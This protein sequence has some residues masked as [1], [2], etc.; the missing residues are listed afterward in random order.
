MNVKSTVAWR[1][2]CRLSRSQDLKSYQQSVTDGT[3]EG[4]KRDS[5]MLRE[6]VGHVAAAHDIVAWIAEL[7][8]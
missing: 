8:I 7:Y 5:E 6:K 1:W 4:E 3:A 2:F